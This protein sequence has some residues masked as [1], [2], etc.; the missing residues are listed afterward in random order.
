MVKTKVV[1]P[2]AAGGTE[3]ASRIFQEALHASP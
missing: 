3:V 1:L 2:H